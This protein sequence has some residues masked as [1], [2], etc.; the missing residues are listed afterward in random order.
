MKTQILPPKFVSDISQKFQEEFHKQHFIWDY[1]LLHWIFKI[2]CEVTKAF[3]F[4]HCLMESS[5]SFK[6]SSLNIT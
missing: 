6:N 3:W 4:Q 2:N 1:I 5:E